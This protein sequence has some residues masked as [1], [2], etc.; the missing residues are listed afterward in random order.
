MTFYLVLFYYER[1]FNEAWQ[2]DVMR[3]SFIN[4]GS[5]LNLPAVKLYKIK[6]DF[7]MK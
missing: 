1:K 5:D 3:V 7:P 2:K 4:S 6:V